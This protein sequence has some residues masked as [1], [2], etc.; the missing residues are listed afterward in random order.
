MLPGEVDRGTSV[1]GPAI[2]MPIGWSCGDV[3]NVVWIYIYDL[4]GRCRSVL[5]GCLSWDRLRGHGVMW[6]LMVKEGYMS[7]GIYFFSFRIKTVICILRRR[8]T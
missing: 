4:I 5:G 6:K 2:G 1:A 7:R 3:F 8:V